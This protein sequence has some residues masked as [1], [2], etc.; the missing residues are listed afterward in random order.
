MWQRAI[1]H[2]VLFMCFLKVKIQNLLNFPYYFEIGCLH[3]KLYENC[4]NNVLDHPKHMEMAITAL[5][6]S[7]RVAQGLKI[8]IIYKM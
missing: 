2:S 3:H 6:C 8:Y 1:T 4:G 7:F 5:I